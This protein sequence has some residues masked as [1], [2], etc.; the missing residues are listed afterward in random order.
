[1]VRGGRLVAALVAMAIAVSTVIGCAP[2]PSQPPVGSASPA[3]PLPTSASAAALATT[4]RPTPTLTPTWAWTRLDPAQ[5]G[6][7][8]PTIVVGVPDG[9]LLAVSNPDGSAE[10]RLT[11]FASPDGRSW[12][13]LPDPD[14]FR[15]H[16][17]DCLVTVRDVER[18]AA[19]LVAVGA[20]ECT[21]QAQSVTA[22]A[23]TSGD[24]LAWQ[25]ASVDGAGDRS[26]AEIV[27]TSGGL[28][29]LGDPHA[30]VEGEGDYREGGT[31][32]WTS[33]D[34]RAWRRVPD[35]DAPK[36][37]IVI[38]RVVAFRGAYYGLMN[39]SDAI[40]H[41][42]LE[43]RVG[44]W[45]SPDALHWRQ[46]AGGPLATSLQPIDERLVAV[47]PQEEAAAT[48]PLAW[49]SADGLAWSKS[50]LPPPIVPPSSPSI[51]EDPAY[52]YMHAERLLAGPGG[53]LLA[54]GRQYDG[55]GAEDAV[56]WASSDGSTWAAVALPLQPG[57]LLD[58]ASVSGAGVIVEG[59]Y[60][61]DLSRSDRTV[62]FGTPPTP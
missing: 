43:A 45:T 31:V 49:A 11:F 16:G 3:G 55:Q 21:E 7:D 34:G 15:P 54:L 61:T 51:D 20:D 19:G 25:R 38:R 37:G 12:S 32:L 39:E 40:G 29:A 59:S 48:R 18:T 36:P 23:W 1:M 8:G 10:A 42:A 35:A 56:A 17:A 52:V 9:R 22:R 26:M 60:G 28:V 30:L 57:F 4:P 24:G 44:L 14:V 27:A 5:F 58:A 2:A 33:T 62:L 13:R 41:I 6:T 46:V 53:G 47:G 50:S